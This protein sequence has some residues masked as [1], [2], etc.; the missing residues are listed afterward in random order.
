MHT[1]L[2]KLYGLRIRG[3]VR[4]IFSRLKTPRGAAL[5]VFTLLVLGAMIGPNLVMT[6]PFWDARGATRHGMACATW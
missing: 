6:L 2:W 1:A 5:G 4:S 3:S